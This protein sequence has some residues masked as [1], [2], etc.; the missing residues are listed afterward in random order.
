LSDGIIPLKVQETQP[1]ILDASQQA[2]VA[3]KILSAPLVLQL[4]SPE[5]GDPGP[6]TYEPVAL[7]PMLAIERVETSE[8]VQYQVGLSS[9]N[10]RTFLENV[11]PQLVRY[12]EDARFIFNDETHQL[13]LIQAA[14]IGREL[15]IET[16][17]QLIQQKLLA[18]EHTI[19]LDME[20]TN[21]QVTDEAT[22]EQLG[23]REAVSVYTSYFYGSSAER[24]QNIQLSAARF[25]GVL[26]PPG[27]TFSMADVLGDVSLDNGYAEALIIFGDRT[28]KGVGGGVCQVSTTLFTV[29]FG[30][31]QI[32]ERCARLPGGLLRAETRR[33]VRWA[34]GG[35]GCH[36]VCTGSGLQVYQRLAILAVDGDL[37]QLEWAQPHLE[38]LFHR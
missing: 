8:G 32:D 29:F 13:E 14:K 9:Q 11:A 27:G 26:I 18:G 4:E 12:P 28:I 19:T 24:M 30:G 36:R 34:P 22:A 1:V 10:L 23:I 33:R 5:E 16:S 25:H 6:W 21:P 20:Y 37:F 31:Y 35:A 15:D 3:K 7:A 38:V 2:E 17:L